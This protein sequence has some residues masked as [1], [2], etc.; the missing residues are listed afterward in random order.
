MNTLSIQFASKDLAAYERDEPCYV[1]EEGVAYTRADFLA[2]CNGDEQV[3]RRLFDLC[4]CLP[5]RFQLLLLFFDECIIPDLVHHRKSATHWLLFHQDLETSQVDILERSNW[6]R[7]G[8]RAWILEQAKCSVPAGIAYRE[9]GE[10]RWTPLDDPFYKAS[11]EEPLPET[12]HAQRNKDVIA[13]MVAQPG[14]LPSYRIDQLAAFQQDGWE[15]IEHLSRNHLPPL[16]TSSMASSVE[17]LWRCLDR[18]PANSELRVTRWDHQQERVQIKARMRDGKIKSIWSR[19]PESQLIPIIVSVAERLN[20]EPLRERLVRRWDQSYTEREAIM[21]QEAQ[22][23]YLLPVY[24]QC[25][26][27]PSWDERKGMTKTVHGLLR[28]HGYQS[29]YLFATEMLNGLP[30][31]FP[32]ETLHRFWGTLEQRQEKMATSQ[33]ETDSDIYRE[34]TQGSS[35]AFGILLAEAKAF[36]AAYQETSKEE[37]TEN[38]KEE[39]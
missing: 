30:N 21:K 37:Q 13:N 35:T 18:L 32:P 28:Q 4:Y 17:E 3:A 7:Q 19:E 26:P 31:E 10:R 15:Q 39:R 11:F 34:I 8:R 25:Y 22:M 20:Q 6:K 2:V 1:D 5:P 33:R 9:L 14:A 23:L 27:D 24:Y 29:A 16:L 38:G 12:D 36:L